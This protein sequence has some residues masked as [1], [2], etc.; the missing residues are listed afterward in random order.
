M[1]KIK[2]CEGKAIAKGLCAK[3][4]MRA[5]RTGDPKQVGKPGR[6]PDPIIGMWRDQMCEFGWSP[7]TM[8]RYVEAMALLRDMDMETKRAAVK[9]ATR[10]N[11]SMNVSKLLDIAIMTLMH[12]QEAR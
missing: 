8:A 1:C 5:R 7:R 10:P 11:G 12:E 3:H 2:G 4:Y 6:P 9:A